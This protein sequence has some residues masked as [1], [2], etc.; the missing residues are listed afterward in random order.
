[1]LKS[2]DSSWSLRKPTEKYA[3]Q[4]HSLVDLKSVLTFLLTEAKVYI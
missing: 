3:D 4:D 2:T 1:M